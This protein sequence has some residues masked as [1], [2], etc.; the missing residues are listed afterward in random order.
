[1]ISDNV[2]LVCRVD[3]HDTHRL[4]VVV[5]K[6]IKAGD[7]LK[8]YYGIQYWGRVLSI[9]CTKNRNAVAWRKDAY[10]R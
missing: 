1:M 6:P 2:K 8:F 3:C 10:S 5:T 4:Q 9:L 7:M